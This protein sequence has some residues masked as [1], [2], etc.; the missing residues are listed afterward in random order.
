MGFWAMTVSTLSPSLGV[1]VPLSADGLLTGAQVA[2]RNA[3]VNPRSRQPT[4]FRRIIVKPHTDATEK[5]SSKTRRLR[6]SSALLPVPRH[7]SSRVGPA[8]P[9]RGYEQRGR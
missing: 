7:S 3:L 6:P 2:Q 9:G 1:F 5:L 4:L 8:T